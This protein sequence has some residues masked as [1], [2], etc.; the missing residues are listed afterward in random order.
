MGAADILFTPTVQRILAVTLAHPDRAFTLQELIAVAATGRGSTQLQI[1]RLLEA[2][3]LIE[4]PR[5][6][7][8]RHI[9]ANIHHLL[10][11]ELCSVSRKTFGLAEPLKRALEPFADRIEDAFVFGSVAKGT[12][13]EKSDVDLAV[14]GTVALIPLAQAT[15]VV[16]QEIGRTIHLH[17]YEQQEWCDL[18]A[19]DPVVHRI[20]HGPKLQLFPNEPTPR[21]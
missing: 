6:G 10:Y 8:E 18:V 17:L 4:E 7:R 2:G 14:V 12:D 1:E 11:P 20:A 19:N 9:K 13:T 16:E 5:R 15:H 21:I 3:L